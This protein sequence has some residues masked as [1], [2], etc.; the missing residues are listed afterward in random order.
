MMLRSYLGQKKEKQMF[1][2]PGM[3][4]FLPELRVLSTGI[5]LQ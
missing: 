1:A 4:D 2:K 5:F 3:V